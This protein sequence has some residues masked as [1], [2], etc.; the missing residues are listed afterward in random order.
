MPFARS[1]GH[2]RKTRKSRCPKTF[3]N[4]PVRKL[5]ERTVSSICT[6]SWLHKVPVDLLFPSIAFLGVGR[7]ALVLHVFFADEMVRRHSPKFELPSPVDATAKLA[8]FG[9]LFEFYSGTRANFI[10]WTTRASAHMIPPSDA[11]S[12]SITTQSLALNVRF[13]P[14]LFLFPILPCAPIRCPSQSRLGW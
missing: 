1:R 10:C 6:P 8:D 2:L 3:W 9:T 7:T 14:L 5:M 12:Y 13:H 11:E 4:L